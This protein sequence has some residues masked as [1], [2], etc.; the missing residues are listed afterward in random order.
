MFLTERE[1][2]DTF[3]KNYNYSKRARKYQFECLIREG[4][5][6]LVTVE[7][8]QGNI[9]FNA[10]E[11]K[12]SDI[13]KAIAQAKANSK[14]VHKSWIV[15]PYDKKDLIENKYKSQLEDIKAVGVIVVEEEGRW[16]MIH[17]P[18][19]NYSPFLSQEIL[20][21]MVD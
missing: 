9:Q 3:W 6:D 16:T 10:F 20:R 19:F 8:Y 11:F 14:W 1:L 18:K 15:I 2:R 4:G 7:K 21:M 12:L 13:K 5:A 17:M